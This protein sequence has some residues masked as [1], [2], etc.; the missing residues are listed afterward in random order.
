MKLNERNLQMRNFFNKKADGYDEVHG[1]KHLFD[2]KCA[3]VDRIPEDARSFLDLGI[4]TGLELTLLFEKIPTAE[5]CGIDISENMIEKL[6]KRLFAD[7]VKVINGDFF[8]Y[9]AEPLLPLYDSVISSSALHHFSPEDKKHIYEKVYASLRSGGCF[10]SA[11]CVYSTYD[12]EK[13]VFDN[14]EQLLTEWEHVDTPLCEETERRILSEAG[15]TEIE[16]TQ[17]ENPLY[18]LIFAKKV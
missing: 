17:L 6:M 12:E 13:W 16:F 11:D 4:G 15:F 2:T 7:R 14:Y 9:T 18:K 10:I 3:L 5:V 1:E 8:D